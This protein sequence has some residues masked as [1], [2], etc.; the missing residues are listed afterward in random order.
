V[1]G[2]R[3]R[4]DGP[5]SEEATEQQAASG[6]HS[7]DGPGDRGRQTAAYEMTLWAPRL[8]RVAE[9][10]SP[11]ARGVPL[12]SD[13]GDRAWVCEA[14]IALPD[15]T[16]PLA[17]FVRALF[18]GLALAR[19]ADQEGTDVGGVLNPVGQFLEGHFVNRDQ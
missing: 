9:S 11:T 8:P 16:R 10:G 19:L 14:G 7:S 3:Q 17:H 12:P 18:D 1:Q 15:E 5:I 4:D 2:G 6:T 13:L